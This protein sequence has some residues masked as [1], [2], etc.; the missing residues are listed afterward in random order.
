MLFTGIFAQV[1]PPLDIDKINKQS[2]SI[3]DEII[4]KSE[5][6]FE[7][8]IIKCDGYFRNNSVMCSEIVK[9][10]KVFRGNL[11]PGSIEV[12]SYSNSI[13]VDGYKREAWKLNSY[14]KFGI[15]FCRIAKEFQFDPKYNIDKVDN[16]EI[17]TY[18]GRIQYSPYGG[19]YE[20]IVNLKNGKIT[21][22]AELY[23]ILKRYPNLNI[24][25]TAEK[26]PWDHDNSL[27]GLYPRIGTFKSG[28]AE[29][30]YIDSVNRSRGFTKPKQ[31]IQ[32]K[33]SLKNVT[34]P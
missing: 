15:F 19:S 27:L 14:D 1:E 25:E 3:R 21:T 22:K 4:N 12:L 8:T 34:R 32:K 10:T 24:P 30:A 18:K 13:L 7:G 28:A 11:V 20:G 2:D 5:Y 33:D 29:D 9:I 31:T 23:K 26:E 6:V 17:L 16:K